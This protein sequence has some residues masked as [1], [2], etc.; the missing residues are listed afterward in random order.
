MSALP[1]AVLFDLDGTL[2]DTEPSWMA[3]E[4]ALVESFGGVW[5]HEQAVACIGNPLSVSAARLR[6]EG[7]VDLPIEE[8]ID[9]LLGGVVR[10]VR[11]EMPWQPGGLELLAELAALGVPCALVTMSYRPLADAVLDVLPRGTFAAVV[12]G[13]E[14]THGKPHPE[15]YLTAAGLLGVDPSRCVVIEDSPAGIGSGLAAGCAVVAVP[16][17]AALPELAGVTVVDSLEVLDSQ[18]LGALVLTR[19]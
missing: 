4:S 5:T 16:H 2:I 3:Q 12:T 15:P 10:A 14:V 11:D 8:I 9:R 19:S 17:L 6:D 7:S 18:R 1:A 13:D